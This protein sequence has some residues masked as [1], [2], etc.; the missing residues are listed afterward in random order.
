MQA[1][2][3]FTGLSQGPSEIRRQEVCLPYP[4]GSEC[5]SQLCLGHLTVLYQRSVSRLGYKQPCL[6]VNKQYV[7]FVHCAPVMLIC[8]FSISVW[9][10]LRQPGSRKHHLISFERT[11]RGSR[12]TLDGT[13]P[14]G[15]GI[16]LPLGF[17][18]LF[19]SWCTSVY[20]VLYLRRE[21][22]GIYNSSREN[23]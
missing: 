19:R 7:A 12:M 8:A 17:G 4:W 23:V 2:P 15:G 13:M 9:C 11:K 14:I 20:A 22:L 3:K 18:F 5:L 10:T 16:Q 1:S 6:T 21:I